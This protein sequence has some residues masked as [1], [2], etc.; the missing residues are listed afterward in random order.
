ML[1]HSDVTFE[2]YSNCFVTLTYVYQIEAWPEIITMFVPILVSA[3]MLMRKF[4]GKTST[5]RVFTSNKK[6]L[7]KNMSIVKFI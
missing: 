2:V 5:I 3:R 4:I 7:E 6:T 1:A